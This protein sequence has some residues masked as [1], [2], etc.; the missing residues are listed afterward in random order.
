MGEQMELRSA[1][2]E[3]MICWVTCTCLPNIGVGTREAPRARRQM[4]KL[5]GLG[6]GSV[7]QKINK[8]YFYHKYSQKGFSW[9]CCREQFEYRLGLSSQKSGQGRVKDPQVQILMPVHDSDTQRCTKL[10]I[11]LRLSHGSH[12]DSHS[13]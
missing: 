4:K 1:S 10:S 6:L 7:L 13:A 9:S 8:M 11:E 12:H 3:N 2:P 5:T